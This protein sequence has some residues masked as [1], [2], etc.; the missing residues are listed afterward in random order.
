MREDPQRCRD[1]RP[2]KRAVLQLSNTVHLLELSLAESQKNDGLLLLAL[3]MNAICNESLGDRLK[4]SE[5]ENGRLQ[6]VVRLK[7]QDLLRNASSPTVSLVH[8]QYKYEELV[9]SHAGLLNVLERRNDELKTYAT[10]NSELRR[11]MLELESRVEDHR[12]RMAELEREIRETR[13]RKNDKIRRLKA[14]GRTLALVH[15]RLVAMLHGQCIA[16]DDV[17]GLQLTRTAESDRGLLLQEIRR[18]NV[19]TYEN[20]RQRQEIECLRAMLLK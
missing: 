9:A 7:S 13:G 20:F 2:V 14:Q 12:V 18:N 16:R 4:E 5:A 8:L 11:K 15:D 10:Q 1:N 6:D 17:I 19:L 3:K